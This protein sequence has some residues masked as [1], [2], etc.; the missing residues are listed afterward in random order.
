MLLLAVLV[1]TAPDLRAHDGTSY[2]GAYRSRDMGATWLG[3]DTGLFLRS[4]IAIGVDPQN[5]SHV[6]LGTDIGLLRTRNGGRQWAR[7]SPE[8]M[9]GP[10]TAVVFGADGRSAVAAGPDGVHRW[11]GAR[12]SRSDVPGGATPSRVITAGAGPAQFYLLGRTR[13]FVSNDDGA[14]FHRVSD[15]LPS[16]ARITGLTVIR[17]SRE[18]LLAVADGRVM[19]SED[20]GHYWQDRSPADRMDL[21]TADL[22]VPGRGWAAGAEQLYRSDDLG[23]TWQTIGR[24][25]PDPDTPIRGVAAD[26]NA[27]VLVVTSHRGMYRSA[28]GGLTWAAQEGGLPAHQ[29]AGPLLVD[30]GPE[31]VLIAGYSLVSYAEIWREAVIAADRLARPSPWRLA[32][33]AL[34]AV[35][36]LLAIGL[37]ARL[38]RRVRSARPA[39]DPSI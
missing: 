30:S 26:R 32:A 13:L 2:G 23:R 34:G 11:D 9:A 37:L 33:I 1:I 36:L 31:G 25:L 12:W 27:H 28:D 10:I 38:I 16:A 19:A 21:V 15:A 7:E 14:S 5:S 24:A 39:P 4:A 35:S 18:I 20:G 3:A 8:S 6:L 29:E 22:M 17:E